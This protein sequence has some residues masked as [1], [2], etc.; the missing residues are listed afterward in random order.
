[1]GRLAPLSDPNI[2]YATHFYDP[3]IFTHQGQDWSN[4]PVRYLQ[5]VPFPAH[6]ADP[7]ITVLLDNLAKSGQN[8]AAG[9]LRSQLRKPWTE[10]RIV[11]DISQAAAWAE[12][13]R[14][15]VMINE[16]G[17]LGWKVAPADRARWLRTVRGA[18]EDHCIGWA[19]WDYADGFGFVNRI[20][21]REIPD[22][23][24]VDALLGDR[25]RN[26]R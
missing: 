15:S 1:L 16:F 11:D 19:H 13:H 26:K 3:M 6:L 9:F 5:R 23:L 20:G 25:A 18:A 4:D 2:V 17:V 8:A 21:G 22:E 24:I 7:A 14:R 10:A 12:R